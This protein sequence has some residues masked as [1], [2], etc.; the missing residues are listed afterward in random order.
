AGVGVQVTAASLRLAW[1]RA[2]DAPADEW[3]AIGGV[4]EKLARQRTEAVE[5]AVLRAEWLAGRGDFAGAERALRDELATRPGDPRLYDAVRDDA[6][7]MRA[8]AG[9]AARDGQDLASRKALY[10][11]ALRG[12]DAAARAR[13]RDELRRAEGPT[14]KS[15]AVLEALREAAGAAAAPGRAL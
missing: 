6:G 11:L 10:A 9:L 7:R 4:V 3:A 2:S 8:L 12:D 14:G 15:A 13:W 5:P 1:A